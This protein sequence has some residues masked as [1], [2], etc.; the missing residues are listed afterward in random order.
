MQALNLSARILGL[1]ASGRLT[2]A[3]I[4]RLGIVDT[5]EVERL[6]TE[7]TAM[8]D[9]LRTRI[10]AVLSEHHFKITGYSDQP[11]CCSCQEGC[12]QDGYMLTMAPEDHDAHVAAAVIRKLGLEVQQV[13]EQ[14]SAA[15]IHGYVTE[16]TTERSLEPL[17]TMN[18]RNP[19]GRD[20]EP[21]Q[22]SPVAKFG[23]VRQFSDE[24]L[25]MRRR[26]QSG[27][28]QPDTRDP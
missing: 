18:P 20:I 13:I 2:E 23:Y 15:I 6:V 14:E 11:M 17:H 10:A 19:D 3:Q 24:D 5:E 27:G 12:S 16:W 9:D 21:V 26:E 25:D 8:T 4:T 1:V 28:I 22:Q 7:W